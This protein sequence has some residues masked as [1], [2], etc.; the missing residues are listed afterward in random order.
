MEIAAREDRIVDTIKRSREAFFE[1]EQRSRLYLHTLVRPVP[2]K[3]WDHEYDKQYSHNAHTS[4]NES[5][6][7]HVR[8]TAC[9]C[10]GL[11]CN[12]YAVNEITSILLCVV[13]SVIWWMITLSEE[14]ATSKIA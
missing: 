3:L 1:R 4:L 13:W 14:A 12:K 6:M 10:F 9:I 5:F 8:V 2:P 7:I 11:L